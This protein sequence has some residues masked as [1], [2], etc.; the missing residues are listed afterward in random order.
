VLLYGSKLSFQGQF[1][2]PKFE[3]FD[4]QNAEVEWE[5][6]TIAVGISDLTGIRDEVQLAF[7]GQDYEFNPSLPSKEVVQSGISVPVDL[8][9]PAPDM[10]AAPRADDPAPTYAFDFDLQLN[11]RKQ[12]HVVPVG[13]TTKV[14]LESD[15]P[16]PSFDGYF[17]PDTRSIDESGFAADWSVLDLNR[18]FPQQWHGDAYHLNSSAFGVEL[19]TPVDHYQKSDRSTKYGFLFIFLTFTVFFF[20]EFLNDNRIHPLQ[21]LMVGAGI[22]VFYVL[23]IALSEHIGFNLSFLAASTG[24]I[25]LITG[26]S[27]SILRD[28]VLT[29]IV[30][31]SLVGLYAFL[32]T[33]L[34]LEM[35][36][37]LIGSLGLFLV[38]AAVMYLSRNVDWYRRSSHDG[39]V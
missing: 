5:R 19:V 8:Q 37:L 12:L 3:Q 22:C 17:L 1:T 34:Q 35:Y 11:G 21:Y 36:A 31:T 27:R 25:G 20:A 2:Q 38:L 28:G 30:G 39:T 29:A 9:R 6:A 24:I 15:H 14:H 32:F 16:S 26:Y 33:I 23:L 13:K 4:M 7:G 18:N 10:K